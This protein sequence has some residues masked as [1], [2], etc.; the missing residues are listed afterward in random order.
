[1]KILL[2]EEQLADQE[3]F[4][5]FLKTH[6]T[7]CVCDIAGST[8]EAKTYLTTNTYDA[9]IAD[10][11][12]GDGTAPDI[13]PL[14]TAAP[15]IVITAAGNEVSAISAMK[16]GAYDYLVK[17]SEGNYLE[18]M[19]V[20][21]Q[22]AI[23][24]KKAEDLS[25][26][27]NHALMTANDSIYITDMEDRIVFVNDAFR[28]C[29]RYRES[30]IVGQL[31]GSLWKDCSTE[32]ELQS[33]LHSVEG[34]YHG[35]FLHLRRDGSEFP[36]MLTRT[37]VCDERGRPFATVSVARDIT[38]HKKDEEVLVQTAFY[39]RLTALPTRAL[40]LERLEYSLRSTQRK[41]DYQFAILFLDLDDFNQ[42]ND[43][44][45]HQAGDQVLVE[46]ARRL[47]NCVRSTDM[48]AR[49]GGDE[50]VVL[51]EDLNGAE[52]A[53]RVA[54]RIRTELDAAHMIG[55]NLIYSRASLGIAISTTGYAAGLQ[56][57]HDAD[58]EM[59]HDKVR[60]KSIPMSPSMLLLCA[61]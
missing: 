21:V 3:R 61:G 39:D 60:R 45:G 7:D 40:L 34:K 26:V 36:V 33:I 22:N 23:R 4:M 56:M 28:A 19:Q 14:V 17:D 10:F 57:I 44:L 11:F 30:E 15:V 2:I 9:V 55:G 20:T 59:Y 53:Q 51:L 54:A 43:T 12:L 48:V 24:R 6:W 50:F 8:A 49:Y 41:P 42:V 13:I 18:I 46:T 58:L 52:D 25:Q 16:S 37:L 31:A 1:M 38:D 32:Q 5:H 47:E 27:L 35:E 29:Y